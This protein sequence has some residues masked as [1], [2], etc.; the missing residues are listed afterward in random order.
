MNLRRIFQLN[1]N[2][3]INNFDMYFVVYI[4]SVGVTLTMSSLPIS[5]PKSSTWDLFRKVLI[6][7][8]ILHMAIFRKKMVLPLCLHIPLNYTNTFYTN[9]NRSYLG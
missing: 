9:T 7:I 6:E 5:K 3:N 8:L 1:Y 4:L 2:S